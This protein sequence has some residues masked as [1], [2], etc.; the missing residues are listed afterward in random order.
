MNEK[1]SKNK[2]RLERIVFFAKNTVDDQNRHS[3]KL[4]I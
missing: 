4:N 1:M 2:E 3:P